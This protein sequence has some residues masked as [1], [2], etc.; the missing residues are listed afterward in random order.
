[1][2]QDIIHAPILTFDGDAEQTAYMLRSFNRLV[3]QLPFRPVLPV[4]SRKMA[5]WFRRE[6]PGFSFEFIE[7]DGGT[8]P[9]IEALSAY[10]EKQDWVFWLTSDRYPIAADPRFDF[11]ALT[12]AILDGRLDDVDAVKLTRWREDPPVGEANDT[13]FGA[14][15]VRAPYGAFGFW[16]PHFVKSPLLLQALAHLKPGDHVSDFNQGLIGAF[17]EIA[18]VSLYP[19]RNLVKVEE[20]I[21]KGRLTLNY[22]T[23]RRR[24]GLR[25]APPKRVNGL[26]ASF[27]APS[28]KKVNH[29]WAREKIPVQRELGKKAPKQPCSIVSFGGVG[30][31]MLSRSVYEAM[32][33]TDP[34]SYRQAHSH[35]R[36]PPLQLLPGQQVVYVLGDPRDAVLSFFARREMRHDRHGFAPAEPGEELGTNQENEQ[37]HWVVKHLR[38][39]Q[40]EQR[41]LTEEWDLATYLDQPSDLFRL[42]EHVDA[43]L[44]A[45]GDYP[46]TF[47]KYDRLWDVAGDLAAHLGLDRLDLPDRIERSSDWRHLD[48]PLREGLDRLYGDLAARIDAMPDVF[49]GMRGRFFEVPGARPVIFDRI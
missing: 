25:S 26:T 36:I 18:S 47:V 45:N 33:V 42:E 32:G 4:Q 13:G 11:G 9:T 7:C 27:T 21:V 3:P 22:E 24:E 6:L 49:F 31:K 16:N 1:M 35:H 43:W 46:V 40:A 15:F 29:Y 17:D 2:T 39:I 34:Q 19:R 28:I 48:Q 8:G 23:R 5:N 10:V 14:D 37:K 44:Y 38:N 41:E 30:S 12:G 20:P